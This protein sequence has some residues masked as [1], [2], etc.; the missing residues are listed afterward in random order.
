[1]RYGEAE[2]AETL[3][4]ELAHQQLYIN[5]DSAFNEAFATVVGQTGAKQWLTKYKPSKLESYQKKLK[6][7]VEFNTLL[8]Q[9]K[10][11]L[12]QIYQ[13]D[14]S[15]SDKR[16]LKQQAFN[17]LQ[18]RYTQVKEKQWQGNGW[19]DSWFKTPLNNARLAGFSTYYDLVPEFEKVLAS[20]DGDLSR[21]YQIVETVGSNALFEEP[22][23]CI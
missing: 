12:E 14:V 5:G 9:T 18:N 21:F 4:H 20:C 11:R 2:F 13:S 8:T 6:A 22:I 19:F 7:T 15:D 1:M 3:F 16:A 23:K 17:D 10:Q